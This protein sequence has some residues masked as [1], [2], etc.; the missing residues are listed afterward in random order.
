MSEQLEKG[1]FEQL[2]QRINPGNKLLRTWELK[3]GFRL[4]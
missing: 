4:K 1:K 2:V 3:G